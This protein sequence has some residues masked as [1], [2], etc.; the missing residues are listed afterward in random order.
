M[1]EMVKAGINQ[2]DTGCWVV[3]QD[4]CSDL[5]LESAGG[6]GDCWRSVEWRIRQDSLG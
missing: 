6:S 1:L 2:A 5:S 4:E 3:R